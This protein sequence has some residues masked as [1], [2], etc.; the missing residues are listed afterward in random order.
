MIHTN[1]MTYNTKLTA[2]HSVYAHVI[3]IT[4]SISLNLILECLRNST[5]EIWLENNQYCENMC[6]Y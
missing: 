3:E 6:T 1:R 5:D 4:L 2:M